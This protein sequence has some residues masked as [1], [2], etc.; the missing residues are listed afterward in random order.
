MV[1]VLSSKTQLLKVASEALAIQNTFRLSLV[2]D[3]GSLTFALLGEVRELVSSKQLLATF[4][5]FVKTS[6]C[7]GVDSCSNI[8]CLL[9]C[10]ETTLIFNI[11]EEFPSLLCYRH[12]ESLDV[13]RTTG[14]VSNLVEMTL[15]LEQNLLVACNALAK[16]IRSLVSLVE[17]CNYNRVYSSQSGRHGLSLATEQIHIRVKYSLSELS[18]RSVDNHLASAVALGVVLLH[19]LSPQHAC[20]TE[21][22]NFHEIYC[23]YT[24]VELDAGSNF[25]SRNTCLGEHCHPFIT[26]SEGIA[27]LLVNE[28]TCIVEHYC[29]NAENTQILHRLNDL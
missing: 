16:V 24:H 27:K 5:H 1:S 22:S 17:R 15:F 18:S 21:L 7:T 14:W 2:V 12:S 10:L 20:C 9:Y 6:L 19:D 3:V 25:L 4:G 26:P 13:V 29:V 8:A 28:S 11:D 23:R